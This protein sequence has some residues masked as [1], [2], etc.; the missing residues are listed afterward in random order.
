MHGHCS[1]NRSCVADSQGKWTGLSV[2]VCRA[3]SAAIFGD[4]EKVR[5]TFRPDFG[6]R[7]PAALHGLQSGEVDLLW[8]TR[9]TR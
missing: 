8:A 6:D 5:S 1:R 4:S 3:V 7:V 9:P 2:D